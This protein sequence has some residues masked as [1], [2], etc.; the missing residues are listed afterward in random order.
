M[1]DGSIKHSSFRLQ[2]RKNAKHT[3]NESS[4]KINR[5]LTD[6]VHLA[7][8][9]NELLKEANKAPSLKIP[10]TPTP[11]CFFRMKHANLPR[12]SINKWIRPTTL[13]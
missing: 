12:L 13:L 7:K 4:P 8:A 6:G 2:M 1:M 5:Q 10:I 9:T 3:R 11:S